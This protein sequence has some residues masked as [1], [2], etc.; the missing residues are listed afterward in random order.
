MSPQTPFY[1]HRTPSWPYGQKTKLLEC[2]SL[3][4]NGNSQL[5][6]VFLSFASMCENLRKSLGITLKIPQDCLGSPSIPP[7]IPF[8]CLSKATSIAYNMIPKLCQA[9]PRTSRDHPEHPSCPPCPDPIKTRSSPAQDPLKTRSRPSKPKVKS[10]LGLARRR[11]QYKRGKTIALLTFFI[12][13]STP[14]SMKT[15]TFV[16]GNNED[17]RRHTQRYKAKGKGAA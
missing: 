4:I 11:A 13:T 6:C 16:V 14:F 1:L 7:K 15:I 2:N 5:C 3:I 10:R 9:L 8:R 12:P 17:K